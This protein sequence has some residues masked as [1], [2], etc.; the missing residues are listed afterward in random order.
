M[1]Q[2]LEHR[3]LER[4]AERKRVERGRLHAPALARVAAHDH[5]PRG[6]RGI[7]R[8]G[9]RGVEARHLGEQHAARHSPRS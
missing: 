8:A 5:G 3:H 2:R 9:D 6:E 7:V 1:P 4:D